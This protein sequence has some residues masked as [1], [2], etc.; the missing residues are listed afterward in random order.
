MYAIS[1]VGPVM[2]KRMPWMVGGEVPPRRAE[3][4]PTERVLEAGGA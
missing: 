3:E 4:D 1:R 2:V